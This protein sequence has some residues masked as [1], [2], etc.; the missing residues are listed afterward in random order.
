MFSIKTNSKMVFAKTDDFF[1]GEQQ[2]EG[3]EG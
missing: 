1:G 2:G 3:S